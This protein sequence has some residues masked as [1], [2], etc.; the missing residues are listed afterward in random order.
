MQGDESGRVLSGGKSFSEQ[1]TFFEHQRNINSEMNKVDGGRMGN[2][3]QVS[4]TVDVSGVSAE[5]FVGNQSADAFEGVKSGR[6]GR[7][8]RIDS[9]QIFERLLN[10]GEY[11]SL[12]RAESVIQG[13]KKASFQELLLYQVRMNRFAARV[14]LLSRTVESGMAAVRRFQSGS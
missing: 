5:K 4:T 13:G 6:S 8:Q 3:M 10:G 2:E 9:G 7:L 1:E 14:E 12:A 11:E